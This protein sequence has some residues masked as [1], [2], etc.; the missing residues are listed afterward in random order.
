M[1]STCPMTSC[2]D[3][4]KSAF[5]GR[6]DGCT[7]L[8]GRLRWAVAGNHKWSL[9]SFVNTN[10]CN[11]MYVSWPSVRTPWDKLG[12]SM[13]RQTKGMWAMDKLDQTGKAHTF[14]PYHVLDLQDHLISLAYTVSLCGFRD[15]CVLHEQ[16]FSVTWYCLSISSFLPSLHWNLTCTSNSCLPVFPW[17]TY[18]PVPFHFVQK[19]S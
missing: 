14:L 15:S 6:W 10:I 5:G 12:V 17:I 16:V 7:G 9:I 2:K 8:I 19:D 13:L 11:L 1:L 18:L 4:E 3:K